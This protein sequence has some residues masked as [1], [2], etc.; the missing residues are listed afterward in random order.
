MNLQVEARK[1]E[2]DG[3]PTLTPIAVGKPIQGLDFPAIL[4]LRQSP[5]EI[6]MLGK[7]TQTQGSNKPD[8]LVTLFD[9]ALE[10]QCEILK[11]M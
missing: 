3:P 11:F 8:F 2:H 4:R 10:L 7:N 1:L 5:N 9:W 6:P